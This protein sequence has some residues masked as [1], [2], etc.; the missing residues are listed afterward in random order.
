M[1]IVCYISIYIRYIRSRHPV[2][3]V[4][5]VVV[6]TFVWYSTLHTHMCTYCTY[7]QS[8]RQFK[9][10]TSPT[11]AGQTVPTTEVTTPANLPSSSKDIGKKLT[12]I[13]MAYT[14]CSMTM[15][16]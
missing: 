4:N 15:P 8:F 16:I 11:A 6:Y 1:Y 3:H 13:M 14:E 5:C 9:S 12:T 7:T 2:L 10:S